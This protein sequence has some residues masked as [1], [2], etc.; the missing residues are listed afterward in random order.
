MAAFAGAAGVLV[1]AVAVVDDLIEDSDAS[2]VTTV[3]LV[4]DDESFGGAVEAGA[5]LES[6]GANFVTIAGSA[7]FAFA[8]TISTAATVLESVD[9]GDAFA[10]T[11]AF[12]DLVAVG[13]VPADGRYGGFETPSVKSFCVFGLL[14]AVVA[15]FVAAI[16][17]S[18]TLAGAR[19]KV[20]IFGSE[21]LSETV[22]ACCS[23]LAGVTVD[24]GF[25]ADATVLVGVSTFAGDAASKLPAI[26]GAAAEGGFFSATVAA[27]FSA[28]TRLFNVDEA[29]VEAVF[30]GTPSAFL[31][32][33]LTLMMLPSGFLTLTISYSTPL[34]VALFKL[35]TAAFGCG[36]VDSGAPVLEDILL[37]DGLSCVGC[38]I[39]G[40]VYSLV[41]RFGWSEVIYRKA[42]CG[43]RSPYV[44]SSTTI[45]LICEWTAGDGSPVPANETHQF[46][47]TA[48]VMG[49]AIT[50]CV[51]RDHL[52]HHALFPKWR[53]V[54][55]IEEQASGASE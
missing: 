45:S 9:V 8:V 6:A 5:I 36:A 28:A 30:V 14:S 22:A 25:A 38:R 39:L 53:R 48:E 23:F 55:P 47:S 10:P 2:L 15:A 26:A 4:A 51:T 37:D 54:Q 50:L 17:F 19:L 40:R 32:G 13:R 46:A 35:V 29:I 18:V 1:A 7:A 12:V 31:T 24:L 42:S 52:R 44:W 11:R 43:D 20:A 49:A 41:K 3:G 33:R 34:A 21:V 16:G 27:V